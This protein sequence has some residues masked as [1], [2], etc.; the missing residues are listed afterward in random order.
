MNEANDAIEMIGV[1]V[2][3]LTVVGRAATT[4][5]RAYWAC[6]C[7]CGCWCIVM[8]KYL[9]RKEVK[10]CGCLNRQPFAGP[11][12]KHGH[13]TNG[14][15]PTYRIWSGII[16]RC[17]NPKNRHYDQYGA[18][19]ITICDRWR[20]SFVAFL[21]DVGERPPNKSM[22]R[23]PNQKGNYEPGNVRWATQREQSDNSSHPIFLTLNGETHN[24]A[25]WSKILGI[26]AG[27]IAYRHR[28][29]WP[30]RRVLA[31]GNQR[32]YLKKNRS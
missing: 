19:G 28:Q 23:Y 6:K 17:T 13:A 30:I 12:R 29:G 15:S 5:R 9:R 32:I 20:K 26:P 22:D 8:G 7:D 24:L 25:G 3:K 11:K 27:N 10:S 1:R 16:Q 21:E 31:P 14:I 18:R 4:K 2:G